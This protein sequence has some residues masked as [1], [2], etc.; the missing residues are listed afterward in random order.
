M[1]KMVAIWDR[2]E[3]GIRSRD[4]AER[5]PLPLGATLDE[6]QRVEQTIGLRLPKVVRDSYLLHNGS[7][8]IWICEHGFLMPLIDPRTK[9]GRITGFGVLN[10]W[11]MML[12][13]AEKMAE[14]RSKPAGP[15]RDDYWN[16][17][18]VPL[19]ENDCG[20]YVC[21]DFAPARGGR[22]GQVIEWLAREGARRVLAKDFT[23]WLGSLFTEPGAAAARPRD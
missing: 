19:T 1:G 7:S 9:K 11:Q 2:I 21:L 20:D 12:P 4:P 23:E 6:I 10:L 3:A 5:R 15:I 22:K 8:R 13:V 14:E 18:W 16:L 17:R